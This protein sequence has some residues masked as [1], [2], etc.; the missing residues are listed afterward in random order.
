MSGRGQGKA[1]GH[2]VAASFSGFPSEDVLHTLS[3][4]QKLQLHLHSLHGRLPGSRDMAPLSTPCQ[5]LAWNTTR[6]VRTR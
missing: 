6:Q 3:P 4:T 5:R 2:H 1:A